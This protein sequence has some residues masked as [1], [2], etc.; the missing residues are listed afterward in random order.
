MRLSFES[1]LARWSAFNFLQAVLHPRVAAGDVLRCDHYFYGNRTPNI[2]L[3]P[4]W[5]PGDRLN[6]C[7]LLRRWFLERIRALPSVELVGVHSHLGSTHIAY[8]RVDG[9]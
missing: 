5:F 2:A 9:L 6:K 1:V 7:S 8:G 4:K 3:S